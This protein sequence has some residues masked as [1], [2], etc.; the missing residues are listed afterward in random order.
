MNQ[1]TTFLT[2]RWATIKNL[3]TYCVIQDRIAIK[4]V[5]KKTS[6]MGGSDPL[7]AINQ[8]YEGHF[9]SRKYLERRSVFADKITP[10]ESSILKKWVKNVL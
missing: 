5:E 9:N 7:M 8:I 2:I 3:K 4:E 1:F 10:E 6:E